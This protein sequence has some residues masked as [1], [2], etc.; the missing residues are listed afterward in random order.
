MHRPNFPRPAPGPTCRLTSSGLGP[1]TRVGS[2]RRTWTL[3]PS[4]LGSNPSPAT[5]QFC[6]LLHSLSLSLL[7]CD[8]GGW[9]HTR[10]LTVET[11]H[12]LMHAKAL[13]SCKVLIQAHV[14]I[15]DILEIL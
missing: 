14:V 8:M 15:T 13:T 5:P 1:R 12:K 6:E 10:P 2:E 11:C 7:I 4:C 9:C 3:E